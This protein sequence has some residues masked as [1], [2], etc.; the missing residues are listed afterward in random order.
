MSRESGSIVSGEFKPAQ[1][2]DLHTTKKYF[3]KALRLGGDV[4]QSEEYISSATGG[5]CR[6]YSSLCQTPE[7]GVIACIDMAYPIRMLEKAAGSVR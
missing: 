4:Y 6:T 3:T 5:L 1:K 7:G 2:G